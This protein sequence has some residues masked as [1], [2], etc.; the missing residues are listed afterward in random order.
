MFKS[1]SILLFALLSLMSSVALA[2]T[3]DECA[4]RLDLDIRV[5]SLAQAT[6]WY[7]QV[8]RECAPVEGAGEGMQLLEINTPVTLSITGCRVYYFEAV[9]LDNIEV[10]PRVF[11]GSVKIH[12]R[13]GLA[14]EW[15]ELQRGEIG[16]V[17]GGGTSDQF[18]PYDKPLP[19]GAGNHQFEIRTRDGADNIEILETWGALYLLDIHC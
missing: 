14:G 3:P 13:H 9:P 11:N 5:T 6:A 12:W 16:I 17:K 2:E 7:E 15:Q 4:A 8:M 18:T 1:L 19:L 10:V